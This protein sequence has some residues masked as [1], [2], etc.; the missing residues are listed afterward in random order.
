[1]AGHTQARCMTMKTNYEVKHEVFPNGLS[2][3]VCTCGWAS[4]TT[5]FYWDAVSWVSLHKERAH[6]G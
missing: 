6:N 5:G 4:F 3:V 1:M 2:Q